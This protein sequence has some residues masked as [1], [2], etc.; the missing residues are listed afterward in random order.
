MSKRNW[1]I[2]FEDLLS[3]VDKIELYI[4]GLSE[5]DFFSNQLIIDAVVRNIE[6]IGEISKQIPLGVKEKIL[7]IPWKALSGIRN[8]IVHEYFNVDV[9]I[10]WQIIEKDL[11]ELKR[12]LKKQLDNNPHL[13]F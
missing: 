9:S 7:E 4:E 3:S 1:I 6:I 8:R 2:L 13:K 11:P 10:I 5:K 12:N